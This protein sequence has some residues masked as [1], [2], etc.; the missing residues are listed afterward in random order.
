MSA[1]FKVKHHDTWYGVEHVDMVEAI[2][3]GCPDATVKL[4][5]R[6]E[7]TYGTMTGTRDDVR[8]PDTSGGLR[9]Y[10][11]TFHGFGSG[12]LDGYYIPE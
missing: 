8:V 1:R 3:R 11:R 5:G 6:H 2:D 4:T 9:G 10:P 12:P 7:T